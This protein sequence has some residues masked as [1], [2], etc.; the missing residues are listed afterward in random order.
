MVYFFKNY[1][2]HF[3]GN[4]PWIYRNAIV[5]AGASGNWL[6]A[7]IESKY[8]KVK[9][10]HLLI[11]PIFFPSIFFLNHS[12]LLC[13]YFNYV[14]ACF[15]PTGA[16]SNVADANSISA[17]ASSIVA[18]GSSNF[19]GQSSNFVNSGTVLRVANL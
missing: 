18:G 5:L 19:T 17:G 6:S 14:S 11:Q 3:L 1:S 7:N 2:F 4:I 9:I 8:G 12:F 13:S 16:N 15:I 10:L